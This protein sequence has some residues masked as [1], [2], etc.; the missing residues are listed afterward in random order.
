MVW[1]ITLLTDTPIDDI[2][3][4]TPGID[5]PPEDL[6]DGE[7]D[8]PSHAPT[9]AEWRDMMDMPDLNDNDLATPLLEQQPEQA[10][11]HEDVEAALAWQAIIRDTATALEPSDEEI[12]RMVTQGQEWE[13]VET[14]NS[15]LA[16]V[17][18]LALSY[19]ENQFTQGG[20]PRTYLHERFGLDV[21]DHPP[22][23]PAT[24]PRVGT[25]SSTTP[26]AKAPRIPN[27]SNPD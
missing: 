27:S 1:K 12:E 16:E 18:A 10:E 7:D 17:N 13:S 15:R 3:T 4:V 26:G 22:C 20:W 6:W 9:E 23:A 25:T 11:H 19:Y 5:E 21:A 14:P 24:P 8:A 2:D